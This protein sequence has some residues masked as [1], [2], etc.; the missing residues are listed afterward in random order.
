[1]TTKTENL[2]SSHLPFYGGCIIGHSDFT[3]RHMDMVQCICSNLGRQCPPF[4][5]INGKSTTLKELSYTEIKKLF[6]FIL[7]QFETN[8]VKWLE[9]QKLG[10]IVKCENQF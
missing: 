5:H 2:H 4:Y 10:L 8:E 1:M 7:D 6:Y 3:F 9:K